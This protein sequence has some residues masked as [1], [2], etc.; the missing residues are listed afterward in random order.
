MPIAHML[1]AAKDFFSISFATRHKGHLNSFHTTHVPPLFS[2]NLNQEKLNPSLV[3]VSI[4]LAIHTA[5]G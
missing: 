4:T 1:L 5:L 3:R 2:P